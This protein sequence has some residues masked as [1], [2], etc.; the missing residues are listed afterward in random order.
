MVKS[1]ILLC[2]SRSFTLQEQIAV[3]RLRTDRDART[4][5]ATPRE[6][7]WWSAYLYNLLM[8]ITSWY[9]ALSTTFQFAKAAPQ[10]VGF[11]WRALW[12]GGSALGSCPWGAMSRLKID[13]KN[14]HD[15]SIVTWIHRWQSNCSWRDVDFVWFRE[16]IR[17][18]HLALLGDALPNH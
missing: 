18:I 8:I 1:W 5:I 13:K 4:P 3:E 10:A 2:K 14:R 9:L 16:F 6:P 7:W 11:Y 12:C 17:N 15:C